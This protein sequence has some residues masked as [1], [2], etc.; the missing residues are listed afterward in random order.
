MFP[1]LFPFAEI[2]LG[3]CVLHTVL[4][5]ALWYA[6][7]ATQAALGLIDQVSQRSGF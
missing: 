7:P 3:L 6:R 2:F 4:T 5:L 1:V